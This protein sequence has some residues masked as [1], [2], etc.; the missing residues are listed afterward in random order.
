MQPKRT[1]PNKGMAVRQ[2]MDKLQPLVWHLA[3]TTDLQVREIAEQVGLPYE[4]TRRWIKRVKRP[5]SA[6]VRMP[7]G[8]VLDPAILRL[9][10]KLLAAGVPV[11]DRLR[12]IEET[13]NAA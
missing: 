9:N 10:K 4:T 8:S 3:K 1:A 7:A 13:R 11:P 6:L 5:A 2:R 12:I